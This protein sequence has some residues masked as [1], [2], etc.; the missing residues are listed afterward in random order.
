MASIFVEYVQKK[1]TA[2]YNEGPLHVKVKG[3]GYLEFNPKEAHGNRR[4]EELTTEDA[5][6]ELCDKFRR[7]GLFQIARDLIAGQ[8]LTNIENFISGRISS[9]SERVELLEEQVAELKK[10]GTSTR[11][12]K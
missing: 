12:K 4:V 3:H 2:G 6:M 5:A 10:K 9:L 7:Q 11:V 1:D 8:D